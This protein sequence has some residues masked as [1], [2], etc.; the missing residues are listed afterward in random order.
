[1]APR[2]RAASAKRATSS[3]KTARALKGASAKAKGCCVIGKSTYPG[4]TKAE[5]ADLAQ[6]KPY[7]WK[8]GACPKAGE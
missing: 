2:K 6:G 3:A 5:C 7:H 4:R 1:M 8:P